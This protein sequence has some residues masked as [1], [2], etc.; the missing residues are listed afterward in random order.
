MISDVGDGVDNLKVGDR[1][2]ALNQVHQCGERMVCCPLN[3][4]VALKNGLIDQAIVGI[5]ERRT[6]RESH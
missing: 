5:A 2:I 4:A 1:V 6:Q 3:G